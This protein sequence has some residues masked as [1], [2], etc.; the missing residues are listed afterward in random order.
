MHRNFLTDFS[1]V[2]RAVQANQNTNFAHARRF[3]AVDV[4]RNR[5]SLDLSR[6]AE[7]HVLANRAD[8]AF[9][10]L[11]DSLAR[12][13]QFDSEQSRRRRIGR[14]FD[15]QSCG[16]DFADHLLE[17]G[18]PR[19]K[20]G[21]GVDLNRRRFRCVDALLTNFH[22]PESTLVML[23]AA[24]VGHQETLALYREAIEE[25]YRFYSFGDAML[26]L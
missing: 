22:L 9:D 2:T 17:L 15:A 10:V 26:L 5:V 11:F 4:S 19:D 23:V 20:V 24:F 7:R 6:S 21:L 16:R 14:I 12:R 18:V 13:R 25:R 8:F 3:G 1:Q